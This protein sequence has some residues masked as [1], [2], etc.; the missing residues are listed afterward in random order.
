M[1]G[2]KKVHII[3]SFQAQIFLFLH[4]IPLVRL[5]SEMIFDLLTHLRPFQIWPEIITKVH[6]FDLNVN[7]P[8]EALTVKI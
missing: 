6:I 7:F 8:I 1:F 5:S 3:H 2:G 4:W